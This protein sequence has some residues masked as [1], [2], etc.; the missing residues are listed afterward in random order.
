MKN[1]ARSVLELYYELSF[2]EEDY[3]DFEWSTRQSANIRM[4]IENDFTDEEQAALKIAASDLLAELLR[5]PDE[6]GYTPRSL[7]SPEQKSF[8]KAISEGRFD[9]SPADL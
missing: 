7:V 5:D 3:V 9:G 2:V 4:A 6:H 8:L 1:L